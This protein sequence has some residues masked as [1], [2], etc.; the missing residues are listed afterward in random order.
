MSTVQDDYERLARELHVD[1]ARK[2]LRNLQEAVR[3]GYVAAGGSWRAP[4]ILERELA[5][6]RQQ[7]VADR[8]ASRVEVP[9]LLILPVGHSPEPLLLSVAYHAPK[10]V[11]LLIEESLDVDYLNELERLWDSCRALLGTRPFREV[12]Q[13]EVR[14]LPESVFRAVR[15]V[16]EGHPSLAK[17]EIVVDVT[18]G[19]K[20][21]IGGA[22]LAAAHLEVTTSYVDFDQYDPVLRRPWPGTRLRPRRLRDPY[23]L[24]QLR[25]TRDLA[26]ALDA[27]RFEEAK[28]MATRLAATAKHQEVQDVLGSESAAA[29][30]MRFQALE[31]VAGAYQLWSE[32]FYADALDAVARCHGL[33]VPPALEVLG[34]L[35]PRKTDEPDDIIKALA[36][37]RIFEDPAV[38]LAYFADTLMWWNDERLE[39]QPR[40]AYMRLYGTME[41]LMSFLFYAHAGPSLELL[42]LEG[43]GEG[44]TDAIVEELAGVAPSTRAGEPIVWPRLLRRWVAFLAFGS[45]TKAVKLLDGKGIRLERELAS[46]IRLARTARPRVEA[47]LPRLRASLVEPVIPHELRS[48]RDEFRDLRHKTTHWLAPISED[49]ARGLHH[50]LCTLVEE[51]VP[52]AVDRLRKGAPSS[53][54]LD[55]W[56]ARLAAVARGDEPQECRPLLTQ[57]IEDRVLPVGNGLHEAAGRG[58]ESPKGEA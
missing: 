38:P 56:S 11:A 27:R 37:D 3:Y 10:G 58:A 12:E 55:L 43:D 28:R 9:A 32:G 41:S 53:G 40:E 5:E 46:Q 2:T 26:R 44:E 31:T 13:P 47:L 54:D 52:Q 42:R 18:G 34:T 45:S 8:S 16:V 24:F 29:E 4:S 49:L 21:M 14:D 39:R 33:P 17:D 22:I 48:C 50:Y 57:E 7:G 30:A 1:S 23:Q 51:L 20:S 19:K 6:A 35:W 15:R 25:E 36:E